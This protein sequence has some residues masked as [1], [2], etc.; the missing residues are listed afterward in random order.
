MQAA[1]DREPSDVGDVT[2]LLRAA[3]GG[4]EPAL[5]RLIPLL[6]PELRRLAQAMLGSERPGH[7]LDATALVHEAWIKLA[8]QHTIGVE[9]R[10]EFFAVAATTMRRVLVDHARRRGRDKRGA[11][12]EHETLDAAVAAMERSCGNLLAL[13]TALDALNMLDPRK[14][15]LVELRFFAGLGM[16]EAAEMLG[17][18]LRQAEREWTT[19]RAFLRGRIGDP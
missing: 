2:R 16:R 18:S 3:H 5:E 13:E 11:G 4:D 17:V 6:Y 8:Q 15:R 10:N 12:V 19:A 7:T 1:F 9:H 14:A